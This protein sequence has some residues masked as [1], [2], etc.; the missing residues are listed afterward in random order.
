MNIVQFLKICQHNR[1]AKLLLI[2]L[3]NSNFKIKSFFVFTLLD[4]SKIQ[5]LLRAQDR[6]WATFIMKSQCLQEIC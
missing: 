6:Y 3:K 4:L 1:Q 5:C 2:F